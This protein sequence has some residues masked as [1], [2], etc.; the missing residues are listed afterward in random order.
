MMMG[1]ST[2]H[3]EIRSVGQFFSTFAHMLD[4]SRGVIDSRVVLLYLGNSVW[5]IYTAIRIL[6]WKRN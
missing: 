5:L 2:P 4:F 3:E 6:E 1:Y